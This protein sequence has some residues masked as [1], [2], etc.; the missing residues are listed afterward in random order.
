MDCD[1]TPLSGICRTDRADGGCSHGCWLEWRVPPPSRTSGF[2][3][4]R[5][6]KE[7]RRR[8]SHSAAPGKRSRFPRRRGRSSCA[9]ERPS[10]PVR[11][12]YRPQLR[13]RHSASR[14][15]T[16]GTVG[17]TAAGEPAGR[18]ATARS[19]RRDDVGLCARSIR[20]LAST[21]AFPSRVRASATSHAVSSALAAVVL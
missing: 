15:A 3:T 6:G 9:R 13:R 20:C 12:P 19:A 5:P 10:A 17:A 1:S 4:L 16:P 14:T 2:T 21:S 8:R 18:A 7:T 11:N